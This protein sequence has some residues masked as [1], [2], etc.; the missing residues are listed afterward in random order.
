MPVIVTD[1]THFAPSDHVP[2]VLVGLINS[3]TSQVRVAIY[4]LD[5]TD[6]ID[7]LLAAVVRGVQVSILADHSQSL[8]TYERP[9]LQRLV[10]GGCTL[11][12]GESSDGQILHSKYVVIDASLVGFGSF[13]F[14]FSA[15]KE[16]NTF[17]VR[18]DAALVAAFTAN[19][20][21]ME[22]YLSTPPGFHAEWQITKGST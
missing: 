19:W 3:A 6:V 8:G 5:H 14:T 17:S 15:Q 4:S 2:P 13:N 16:D 10:D 21:G 11:L 9:Q 22:S 1:Q 12:I 18:S 7:A 20:Q